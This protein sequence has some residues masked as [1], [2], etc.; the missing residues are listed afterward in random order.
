MLAVHQRCEASRAAGIAAEQAVAAEEPHV[1]RPGHRRAVARAGAG[2]APSAR[3]PRRWA[4]SRLASS[5][6]RSTSAREKPVS[7][8]SKSRSI[9]RLQLDR[10]HLAVPAGIQRELV[11]GDHVGPPLGRAEMGQAQGRDASSSPRSLA[12]STRPWPAMIS[13]SSLIRTGLVKP[14]RSMLTWRSA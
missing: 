8:T 7:S 2:L 14:K 12:A 9:R 13:F 6:T 1:A 3:R 10:Q 5:I 11:V 4:S